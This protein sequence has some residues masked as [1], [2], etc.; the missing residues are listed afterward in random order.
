M[1]VNVR[2]LTHDDADAAAGPVQRIFAELSGTAAALDVTTVADRVRDDRV[3]VLVAERDGEVLGTAT[4]CL[5]MTLTKGL[6]GHVE[7]VIVAASAR[8]QGVGKTAL[9]SAAS[10]GP[11]VRP[12]DHPSRLTAR[13]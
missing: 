3:R 13:G 6:V 1:T 7:D 12:T 8:G 11:A 4:L 10:R 5:V 9:A 2:V